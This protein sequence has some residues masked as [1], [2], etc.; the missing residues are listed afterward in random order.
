[1]DPEKYG[2]F[3]GLAALALISGGL[4]LQ[5]APSPEEVEQMRRDR[6][7]AIAA[8]RAASPDVAKAEAK[9]KRKADK[10]R[11]LAEARNG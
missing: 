2:V 3:G 10:L 6:E 7:A 11:A 4:R 8:K 1:M 5:R 9:R